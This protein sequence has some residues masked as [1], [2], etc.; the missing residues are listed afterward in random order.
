VQDGLAV[1]ASKEGIVALVLL[2]A[3]ILVFILLYLWS[4]YVVYKDANARGKSGCLCA[5]IAGLIAWP[6]SLLFWLAFRPEK[7]KR[8]G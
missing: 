5:I 3:A 2:L 6:W 8:K 1:E 4:V 7:L